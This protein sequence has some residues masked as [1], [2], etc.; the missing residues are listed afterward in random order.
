M[1]TAGALIA[2]I[3]PQLIAALVLVFFISFLAI[4]TILLITKQADEC[5]CYGTAYQRPVGGASLM[6]STILVALAFVP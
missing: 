3:V 5:G 4:D 2:G 1:I 6:G